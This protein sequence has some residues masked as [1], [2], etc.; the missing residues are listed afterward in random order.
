[1]SQDDP[2]QPERSG[3]AFISRDTLLLLGALAFLIIAVAL[4]FVFT[5]GAPDTAQGTVTPA[6]VAPGETAVGGDYPAPG[7]TAV[8]GGY[9]AP[10]E[11]AVGDGYP[12]P[13]QPAG[14]IDIV[15]TATAL[16][17]QTAEAPAV[18]P[19]NA[20]GP[21]D[22]SLDE[23]TSEATS[24]SVGDEPYPAP[25]GE[26]Y[27]A[28]GEDAPTQPTFNPTRSVPTSPP[29][30]PPAAQN[31]PVSQAPTATAPLAPTSDPLP[32]PT[33][34]PFDLP[35]PTPEPPVGSGDE[36][37]PPPSQPLPTLPPALPPA[38]VLRGN[39]R[40]AASQ[41]PIILRRDVQIAPGA[42]LIIEP[43]V[44]VRL[45]PGVS[46]YVDG[47]RLLALGLP[48]RRVRFVG[49]TGARW[50]G[51]YGLPNG[52][53]VFENTDIRG[54]GAGGTVIAAE[55]S[56]L[57]I[58][59]SMINDNGGS[60]LLTDTKLE[61]LDSELAGNDMPYGAAL[62]ASYAR[63]NFV[64]L[65]NN[66]I[67]GNL[68]SEGAPMVRLSNQST[69]DTLNLE[70]TGNLMRGGT[71]NLQLTTNGQLNGTITCN[72]L[73][74]A[75][76]GLSLRTQTEQVGPNGTYTMNLRVNEN[77]IDEHVPPI[78]PVYLKYGLGR[79]AAS[80]ILVDMRNNWWGDPTGPY[81]PNEN[82]EGR[83]DSVGE[84]IT[85]VPWLT[86]APPCAP[87]R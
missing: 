57:I 84:N 21:T 65:R 67:A 59:S 87:N 78:I 54:G 68:L 32:T 3:P 60:I 17:I 64:T 20:E 79:G 37:S 12:V 42:E 46:I 11:T 72:A 5:P 45:E 71:P 70:I 18:V 55:R 86:A 14:G 69:F 61:M 62:D 1:M 50:S 16:A 83:G 73:V 25:G 23:P 48:D 76:L 80:E 85:F 63:G 24:E 47:G 56:E 35:T 13:N 7:E 34:E 39:V 51:I 4:T 19:T 36:P 10:A 22:T 8:G 49:N 2:Q 58:R 30:P 27:P 41:S 31:T 28:P 15:A 38:D 74:G 44:E 66:R 9:P 75:N 40:W 53:M 77:F 82:P 33:D 26:P 52:F 29:A 43:G 6:V 81:E